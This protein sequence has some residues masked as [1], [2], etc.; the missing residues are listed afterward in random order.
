MISSWPVPRPKEAW[1]DD[2]IKDFELIQEVVRTIRNLRAEKNI[3]PGHLIP[4]TFIT[5]DYSSKIRD[6]IGSLATLAQLDP[7][8]IVIDEKLEQKT[9]DQIALVAGPIEIYLPLS[10]LMDIKEEKDRLTSELTGILDQI[11]RL[12]EL[13][14]S[15]FSKKAPEAVVKKEREKLANYQETASTIQ[16]QLDNLMELS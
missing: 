10:G 16:E 4:A 13:L 5:Q 7:D 14:A 8:Q 12:E 3:K 15:P 1:E 6:E 2:K 11:G 9:K